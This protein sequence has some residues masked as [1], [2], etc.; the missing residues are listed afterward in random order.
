MADAKKSAGLRAKI[1]LEKTIDGWLIKEGTGKTFACR[2]TAQNQPIL[3]NRICRPSGRASSSSANNTGA[4]GT[5]A[6]TENGGAPTATRSWKRSLIFIRF[7]ELESAEGVLELARGLGGKL[8]AADEAF[9]GALVKLHVVRRQGTKKA[10][11]F[12]EFGHADKLAEGENG[13]DFVGDVETV[14]FQVFSQHAAL[15]I[16]R[17]NYP[18]GGEITDHF[19]E[20]PKNIHSIAILLPKL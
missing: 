19:R 5:G 2:W 8:A 15:E 13:E 9:D 3:T 17:P 4:W 6:T 7:E 11:D 1:V 14:I 16:Q 12:A 20:R 10:H 18:F